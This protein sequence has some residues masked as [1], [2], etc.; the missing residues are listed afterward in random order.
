MKLGLLHFFQCPAYVKK[1]L[2]VRP[3]HLAILYNKAVGLDEQI[4]IP[5]L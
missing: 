3:S 1:I 2:V 5:T 4:L